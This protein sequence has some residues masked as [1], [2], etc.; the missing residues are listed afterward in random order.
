MMDQTHSMRQPKPTPEPQT[1]WP[2]VFGVLGVIYASI[3]LL[4]NLC[5]VP[6]SIFDTFAV[7]DVPPD[8]A[9]LYTIYN[10]LFMLLFFG[11]GLWC[12][13]SSIGILKRKAKAAKP[14]KVW[15]I[16]ELCCMLLLSPIGILFEFLVVS[17]DQHEL[18]ALIIGLAIGL[19][20]MAV[21]LAFLVTVIIWMSRSKIK[22]EVS[23]WT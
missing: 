10:A 19:M 6:V 12:L 1:S 18:I 17:E 2:T 11:L 20:I 4:G 13:V 22:D 21:F 5:C 8:L 23:T 9:L 15:A 7:S 3:S 16:T 14:F